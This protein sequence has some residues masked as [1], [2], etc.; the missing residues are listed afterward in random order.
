MQTAGRMGHRQMLGLQYSL[1]GRTCLFRTQ[2]NAY[3]LPRGSALRKE[4]QIGPTIRAGG[5]RHSL[6]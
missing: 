1:V 4:F 6:R 2:A 3:A 5:H